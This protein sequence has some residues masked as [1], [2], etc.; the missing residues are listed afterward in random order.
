MSLTNPLKPDNFSFLQCAKDFHE[1]K[2]EHKLPQHTYKSFLANYGF[3]YEYTSADE[4]FLFSWLARKNK[5]R[6]ET[7]TI[8]L[9]LNAAIEGEI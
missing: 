5:E 6:I 4:D 2:D 9:L 1:S 3:M 8:F 7:I